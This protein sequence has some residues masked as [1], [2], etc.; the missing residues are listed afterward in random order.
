MTIGE[1][2]NFN[3]QILQTISDG[4]I[5]A[6]VK[7]DIIDVN[8]SY[9]QMVKYSR[10]ELLQMNIRELDVKFTLKDFDHQIKQMIKREYDRFETRH[11][12]KDGTIID[13]EVSS[14]IIPREKEQL[15]AAFIRDITTSRR[16]EEALR[17]SEER[18]RLT[19][20]TSPDSININRMSDGMYV[21]INE[22]FSN[23]MGYARDEVIGKSSLEL[24][25]WENAQDRKQLVKMLQEKGS[26]DNFEAE[27]RTKDGK[28]K[29]GLMSASTINLNGETHIISVT[30]DITDRKQSKIALE[31]SERMLG[32]LIANMPGMAYRCLSDKNWTMEFVSEGSIELT[33]YKPEDLVRNKVISF[34]EVIHPEDRQKVWKT[35]QSALKKR[36]PF[37]LE[38]RIRTAANEEKWVWEKGSGIFSNDKKLLALEGFITDITTRKLMEGAL[39]Q[40]EEKYRQLV[41]NLNDAVYSVDIHGII[42]YISPIIYQMAGYAAEEVIGVPFLNFIHPDDRSEIAARFKSMSETILEPAEY[43]LLMKDGQFCFVRSS[44]RHLFENG[45][46]IGISGTLT[47]ISARKR[48]EEEIRKLSQA[49][50]QSPAS[51]VITDLEGNLEYVN[52][53]FSEVTGY[54][55]EE[56]KGMNPRILNSGETPRQQYKELWET[57]TS[58]L[59]WNGQFHNKK[60]NGELFWE[61]AM[62]SPIFNNKNKITHYLGIK[63]DITEKK[64]L[65]EQ[66]RQSQKMEAIGQLAGGVAHDFN[67]LLTVINGYTEL[68][69]TRLDRLDP[70]FDQVQQIK[71][72]G[73]RA[74]TLTRQLLAFSRRQILQPK[75]LDANHLLQNMEKMLH[76]VIGENID[77]ITIYFKNLGKINADPGQIEQVILNLVVNARDAMP[78]GG[79]LTV[80]TMNVRLT[81]EFVRRHKGATTGW[82]VMLAVTDTGSGMDEETQSRIFEPFYTTKGIGKGTGL[83]LSTVYGIVKQSGGS[84][85]VYS[86]PGAGTSIKVY[87][88][89]IEESIHDEADSEPLTRTAGGTET[90]L[91]V[92][93]DDAVRKLASISLQMYGYN[94]ITAKDG[95]EALAR[96]ETYTKDI[97]LLLTDVI[98]PNISGREL[99]RQLSQ[100]RPNLKLLFMSGYTDH[101]IVEHGILNEK[102]NFIQKPFSPE[103]LARKVREILDRKLEN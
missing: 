64:E 56:V 6:D 88:P 21:D 82:F 53:K 65:E 95:D 70:S 11:K 66:F 7:G 38:Y 74:S 1:K 61:D 98:M 54:S 37:L 93:D 9:C 96:M 81:D 31:E 43:R 26:V 71:Q 77:L 17:V 99:A 32:T 39:Q 90:I 49:V 51:V 55:F 78:S 45:V 101:S 35:V 62:I 27:F 10:N 24:N 86:E 36:K 12:G 44:N 29:T 3:E 67:N 83:G 57:I 2:M 14:I 23:S 73:H 8:L 87:I 100:G 47:D 28:L 84:I 19:F 52:Q 79:K 40:S 18:F 58:G 15:I 34:G 97:Q 102:T 13:L 5:L 42:T 94:I 59:V 75:V 46:L 103:F 80:E 91:I 41:E 85:W 68:V 22:G 69:L 33:G 89:L 63:E 50:E 30:R 92:E 60:K 20:T 76:R 48:A 72:A 25:I 16:A 4:Y